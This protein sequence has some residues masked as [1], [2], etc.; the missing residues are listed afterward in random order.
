MLPSYTVRTLGV[1]DP[2]VLVANQ[3]VYDP[4]RMWFVGGVGIADPSEGLQGYV[5]QV[6]AT[7]DGIYLKREDQ[8][9]PTQVISAIGVTEC[10]AAFDQTMRPTV[11]YVQ[12]G[13]SKHWWYDSTIPDMVTTVLD[14]SVKTPRACMDE[15][16]AVNIQNS[17]VLLAYVRDDVLYVRV[18]RERY[19]VEHSLGAVQ[20]G[21][22]LI[23][24]GCTVGGRVGFQLGYPQGV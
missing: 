17:D 22:L 2:L 1:N 18:Q 4:R 16:R 19:E 20:P 24:M 12:N 13:V 21:E 9:N 5:W 23:R 11:A 7:A 3:D 10:S 15:L 14:V 8:P 6:Y